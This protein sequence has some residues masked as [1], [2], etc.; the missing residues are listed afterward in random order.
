M[1]NV[2]AVTICKVN[3][4]KAGVPLVA[5]GVTVGAELPQLHLTLSCLPFLP[6]LTPVLHQFWTANIP[7]KVPLMRPFLGWAIKKSL[8]Y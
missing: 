5:H 4:A 6:F 1:F 2:E 3:Q 8:H 7:A